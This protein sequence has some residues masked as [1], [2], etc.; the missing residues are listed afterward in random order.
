MNLIDAE[1]KKYYEKYFA[2][3]DYK[4]ADGSPMPPWEEIPEEVKEATRILAGSLRWRAE[5]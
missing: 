2:Q 5:K 4:M 1:A 3:Y